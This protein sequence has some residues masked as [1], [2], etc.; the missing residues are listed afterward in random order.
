MNNNIDLENKTIYNFKT[1]INE[2]GVTKSYIDEIIVII[3][4]SKLFPDS[5][6][7]KAHI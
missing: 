7:L 1:P 4:H 6:W 3:I 2:D 5:D